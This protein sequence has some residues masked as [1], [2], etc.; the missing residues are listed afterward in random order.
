MLPWLTN[1]GMR[2]RARLTALVSSYTFVPALVYGS[3]AGLAPA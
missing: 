2:R 1:R 3:Q